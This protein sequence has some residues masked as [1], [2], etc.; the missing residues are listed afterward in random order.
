VVAAEDLLH[1]VK[2]AKLSC[3]HNGLYFMS[4]LYLACACLHTVSSS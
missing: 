4:N 3:D 2:N 1:S